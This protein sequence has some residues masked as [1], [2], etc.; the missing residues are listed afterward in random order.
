ML[1][2]SSIT[3]ATGGAGTA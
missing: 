3:D 2:D 1:I